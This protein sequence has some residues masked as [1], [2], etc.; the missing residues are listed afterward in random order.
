MPVHVASFIT[1]LATQRSQILD[2]ATASIYQSL[3]GLNRRD[4]LIDGLNMEMSPKKT[5]WRRYG[6]SVYNTSTISATNSN[7]G[8]QPVSPRSGQHFLVISDTATAV[9][10]TTGNNKNLLFTKLAGAG[11][12]RFQAVGNLLLA[13]DGVSNWKWM[14]N[15]AWQAGAS[16]SFG[17]ALLDSNFNTQESVGLGV[18]VTSTSIS[19]GMLTVNYSGSATVTIGDLWTFTNLGNATVLNRQTVTISGSSGGSFTAATGLASYST[20]AETQGVAYK[21]GAAGASD[22][23]VPAWPTVVGKTIVDG[24]TAWVCKGPSVVPIQSQGPQNAPTAVNT[25]YSPINPATGLP[26]DTWNPQAPSHSM[27]Y[28]PISPLIVM[29]GNVWEATISGGSNAQ[30]AGSVPSF[31]GGSVTDGGV[32][33]TNQGS[34]TRVINTSYAVGSAIQVNSTFSQ[35][36]PIFVRG[37]IVGYRTTYSYT[38]SVYVCSVAGVSSSTATNAISWPTGAGATHVDGSVTWECVAT[39]SNNSSFSISPIGRGTTTSTSVVGNSQFIS[40]DAVVLDA[41]GNL[42]VANTPGPSGTAAPAWKTVVG[43]TTADNLMTWIENGPATSANSGTWVYAYSWQNSADGSTTTASPLSTAVALTTNSAISVSGANPTD[44]Q[45]DTIVVWRSTQGL[46]VPFFQTS[47][48]VSAG[49]SWTYTDATGDPGTPTSI[50]NI[51]IIAPGYLVSNGVVT[52]FSD[53]PAVGFT[54]LAFYSGFVFGSVGNV[55]RWGNGPNTTFGNGNTAFSALNFSETPGTITRLWPTTSGLY[56]FTISGTWFVN[57]AGSAANPFSLPQP[58]DPN[59]SLEHYDCFDV[60]GAMGFIYTSDRNLYS[61]SLGSGS[62]SIGDFI[63]DVLQATFDPS[64]AG[65]CFYRN[66][67]DAGLYIHDFSGQW[68][69]LA[70]CPQPETGSMWSPQAVIQ[71]GISSINSVQTSPGIFS[72]LIGP[73]TSGMILKRDSTVYTDNGSSYGAFAVVGSILL[74]KESQVVGLSFVSVDCM[75]VGRPPTVGILPDEFSR[76]ANTP[77]FFTMANGVPDPKLAISD[78]R[79]ILRYYVLQ[80]GESIWCRDVQVKFSFGNDTVPNEILAYTLC[81]AQINE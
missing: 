70:T 34:A 62:V 25:P 41:N 37:T 67:F 71:G 7:T 11:A 21:Q 22:G 3:Y 23:I 10:E 80:T 15:D 39:I 66:G 43:Q 26:Y 73:Q 42:Q 47:F 28:W 77:P 54:N 18:E 38:S 45:Y 5:I 33:W 30:V 64:A 40:T 76:Q 65:L 56:I 1:G 13:G 55:L 32:V 52:N 68:Y 48:P 9:Y 35:Q 72:M 75:K 2:A 36:I 50:L 78:T 53:P 29:S 44:T 8:F 24:T 6:N 46:T 17:N 51:A 79:Y 31:T 27:F 69:R 16:Y 20:V 63:A 59:I 61:L 74:C 19:G 49:S 81:A 12:T 57:G 60:D 14:W 58:I 4:S